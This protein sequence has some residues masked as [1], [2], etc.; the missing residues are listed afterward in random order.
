L[1]N[2]ESLYLAFT[3]VSDKGLLHLRALTSLELLDLSGTNVTDAGLEHLKAST[4][5]RWLNVENTKVTD[6]GVK[7]LQKVLPKCE[8]HQ[9]VVDQRVLP[10][11]VGTSGSDFREGKR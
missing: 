10:T 6:T 8:I 9:T 7:M 1:P 5:L 11:E 4:E 3:K 2:L